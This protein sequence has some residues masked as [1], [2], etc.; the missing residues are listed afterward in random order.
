MPSRRR[1]R[2]CREALPRLEAAA[3]VLDVH[4]VAHGCMPGRGPVTAAEKH[5]GYRYTLTADL[6]DCFDHVR[7]DHLPI[8]VPDCAHDGGVA[9]QGLPS[10]PALANIQLSAL[11]AEIVGRLA[12]RG[13]YTR[14]VDDLA[15]SSNDRAVI[16]EMRAWLPDAVRR[17]GHE[18]ARHKTRLQSTARRVICGVSVAHDIRAPRSTK[19][20]LR[21]AQ[22]RL[23][24][25]LV[26]AWRAGAHLPLLVA[27][28][29]QAQIVRGLAEWTQM[30]RPS[31]I[32]AALRYVGEHEHAAHVI[33]TTA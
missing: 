11:D 17:H 23:A 31:A 32:R 18:I 26:D 25:M 24:T 15:I 9:R 22:H 6:A 28:L 14:Y 8:R 21:A 12:G 2:E 1:K 19:R 30:R 3:L 13:V 7:I 20:R 4:R 33:A 16:D 29:Y 5:V 10:S 27:A